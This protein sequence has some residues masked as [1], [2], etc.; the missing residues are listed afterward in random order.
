METYLKGIIFTSPEIAQKNIGVDTARYYFNV[1]GCG[2]EIKT[3]G[4]G[5]WGCFEEYYRKN[6]KDRISDAVVLTVA[7]P[8]NYDFDRM[9]QLAGISLEICSRTFL[10]SRRKKNPQP[11]KRSFSYQYS[12]H[13][14]AG[15]SSLF[16]PI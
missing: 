7:I 10:K 6:G 3:E 9:K 2:D 4:D 5:W 15:G 11:V 1:N 8:E 14:A 12:F 13:L 16:Y